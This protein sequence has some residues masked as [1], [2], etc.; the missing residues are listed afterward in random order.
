M[1]VG[2]RSNNKA[3]KIAYK[4]LGIP[5][6]LRGF[7]EKP[8]EYKKKEESMQASSQFNNGMTGLSF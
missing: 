1:P 4:I 2:I 3:S 8:R 7:I 5:Q 6:N